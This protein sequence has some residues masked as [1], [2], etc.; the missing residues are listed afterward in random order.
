MTQSGD[1]LPRQA[2]GQTLCGESG[3]VLAGATRQLKIEMFCQELPSR[4]AI[5]RSGFLEMHKSDYG[6][7][8]EGSQSRKY[9]AMVLWNAMSGCGRLCNGSLSELSIPVFLGRP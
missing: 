6:K 8:A 7:V 3:A 1:Y 4:H 5:T 9:V 2:R